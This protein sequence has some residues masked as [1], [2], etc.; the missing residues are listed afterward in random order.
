MTP[1]Q[2]ASRFGLGQVNTADFLF[3]DE[4][5]EKDNAAKKKTQTTSPDAKS[6]Y[7]QMMDTN[8]K[9]PILTQTGKVRDHDPRHAM[10]A[11]IPQFTRRQTADPP[12][13]QP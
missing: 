1:F 13:P 7:L 3:D 12:D 10:Q 5:Q 6:Y 11:V 2:K 8:D 4:T 9:F